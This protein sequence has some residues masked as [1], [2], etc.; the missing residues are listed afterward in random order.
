M[1]ERPDT[2]DYDL[3]TFGEVAAR[4]SERVAEEQELLAQAR[5]DDD[6]ARIEACEQR[7]EVL[8]AS[9]ERY[10]REQRTGEVFRRRFDAIPA[11]PP[12]DRPTW[13]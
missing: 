6:A 2:D 9:V 11:Q 7:I 13:Q 4:L 12:A 10:G 1:T 8:R 5:R 3:L